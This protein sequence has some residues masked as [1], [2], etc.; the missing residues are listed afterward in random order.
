M[1]TLFKVITTA[2]VSLTLS[3]A[4]MATDFD[5][6][7]HTKASLVVGTSPLSYGVGANV[8]A[9]F[10]NGFALDAD[11]MLVD[12]N[13]AVS[14]FTLAP[15]FAISKDNAILKI[16]VPVGMIESTFAIGAA[17]NIDFLVSSSMTLGLGYTY[18]KGTQKNAGHVQT[19]NASIGWLL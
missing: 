12:F 16:K 4:A 15:G 2:I 10:N 7:L 19:A 6:K 5:G 14:V 3:S 18:L 8:S 1:N 13:N 9:L 11:Y 17:V